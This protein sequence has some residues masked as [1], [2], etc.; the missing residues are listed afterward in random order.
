MFGDIPLAESSELDLVR[1]SVY[2]EPFKNTLYV[3]NHRDRESYFG[4]GAVRAATLTQVRI[5]AGQENHPCIPS[6]KCP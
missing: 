6:T 4:A 3:A 2:L 5:S 1:Y